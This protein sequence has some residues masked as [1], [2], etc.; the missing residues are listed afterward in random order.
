VWGIRR[1]ETNVSAPA[2][3]Q[4][5]AGAKIVSQI[6]EPP[7]IKHGNAFIDVKAVDDEVRISRVGLS[8]AKARNDGA[9][10]VDSGLRPKPANHA[11]G[12][13]V[14]GKRCMSD[15]LGFDFYSS[16]GENFH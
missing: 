3:K 10:V 2:D 11:C 12:S 4:V 13:H 8:G 14:T 9:V 16:G 7:S 15:T 6:V 5:H 1:D